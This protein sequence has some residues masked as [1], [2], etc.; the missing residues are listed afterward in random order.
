MLFWLCLLARGKEWN[1]L[2]LL[3]LE[4]ALIIIL[5][6]SGRGDKLLIWFLNVVFLFLVNSVVRL[7]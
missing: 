5:L 4:L 3:S 2:E 1:F 6:Q 7:S